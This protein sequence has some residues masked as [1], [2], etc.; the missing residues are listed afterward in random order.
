MQ[1]IFASV[2]ALS[3]TM[4]RFFDF[5]RPLD[6]T[7]LQSVGHLLTTRFPFSLPWDIYDGLAVMVATP[8]LPCLVLP[9]RVAG[10]SANYTLPMPAFLPTLALWVRSGISLQR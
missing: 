5:S 3:Q 1:S 6:F 2:H 8:V 7:P 10:A 9:F 4:L